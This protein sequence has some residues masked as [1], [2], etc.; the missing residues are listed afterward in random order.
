MTELSPSDRILRWSLQHR[1]Q[2]LA[3]MVSVG[4]LILTGFPIKY[5]HTGW[6]RAMAGWFGG[7]DSLLNVHL[8][9]A[10]LMVLAGVYHIVY[11]LYYWWRHGPTWDMMPGR[12]DIA[13]AVH[14][15]LWLVGLR[16]DRPRYGRY[17]YLEKFEYFAVFWG[18][19]V[20]GGS[21]L[22][23][24]FPGV[25]THYM[26]RWA[27]DALRVVHSNEAFVA[28]LSLAF[29]HFF[30]VHFAPG[31]FPGSMV[32]LDGTTTVA[33]MAEEHPLELEAMG[34]AAPPEHHAVTARERL[35]LIMEMV[36][37]T[38]VTFILLDTFIPMFISAVAKP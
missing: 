7:F 34:I 27:V 24:L 38:L 16:Q 36:G 2:H 14:H 37:Y 30:A 17:S 26:P 10:A 6:G 35:I 4:V 18:F 28:L 25:A 21:G 33:H 8:G 20:M 12:K 1:L 3:L 15:A 29:G 19:V 5:S 31:V 13:D 22:V 32:W 9:A 23:I 11:V